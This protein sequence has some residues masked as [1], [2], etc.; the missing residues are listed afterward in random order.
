MFKKKQVKIV[1]STK[2][3]LLAETQERHEM[4]KKNLKKSCTSHK[5]IKSSLK[6]TAFYFCPFAENY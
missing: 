3:S 1:Y 4:Q 2:I 5:K 6:S